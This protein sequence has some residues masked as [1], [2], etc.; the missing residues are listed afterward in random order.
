MSES[1]ILIIISG[2]DIASTNQAESLL[3]K[4]NWETGVLVE[5]FKTWNC[6]EVRLWWR[7]GGV[8]FEDNLEIRWENET[9]EKVSE[10][11][12]PSR[13]VAASGMPCLTIHP[14]G[15][16][17]YEVGEKLPFG[18]KPADAPP[19]SPRMS[20]WMQE[21]K[22]QAN[23]HN[24]NEEF[25]VSFETTHHGPWI[26]VPSLFIE[27]GS[28]EEKWGNKIAASALADVIINGL[29]LTSNTKT[30]EIISEKVV[31]CLGGGHYAPQPMRLSEKGVI[32]GHMLANYALE[33]EKADEEKTPGKLP[34]GPWKQ[35]IIAA[36]ES[37]KK[38]N[39]CSEIWV[40]L[41]RKSFKGW[42]RNAI[43]KFLE[44]NKI[45]YGRT[46]DFI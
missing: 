24:L 44:I 36:Y 8:L 16:P 38:A 39:P 19:P 21:L 9:G 3:E 37:T 5:G 31:L 2:G 1:V 45:P 20:T 33:M 29:N 35:A 15:T 17:Q 34:E 18:G 27:I 43:M 4:C 42:Q 7:D 14:I 41:D 25:I 32:L 23:I 30:P 11:I 10:V 12:F 6:K 22:K 26:T 46:A 28:T 13:H 40:Y